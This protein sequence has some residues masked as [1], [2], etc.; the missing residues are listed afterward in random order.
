MV[1]YQST[2]A[3]L[4]V[5]SLFTLLYFMKLRR[6]EVEV[7]QWFD[8]FLHRLVIVVSRILLLTFTLY[9]VF[10]FLV[11]STFKVV[12]LEEPQWYQDLK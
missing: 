2:S 9:S 7:F 12:K 3:T 5:L 6:S 11:P 8:F 10:A 1:C 4:L